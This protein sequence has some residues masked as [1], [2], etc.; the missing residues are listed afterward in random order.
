M[1]YIVNYIVGLITLFLFTILS[2]LGCNTLDIEKNT[3]WSNYNGDK[4]SSH[5]S[6]LA[7]IDTNNVQKLKIAWVFKSNDADTAGGSVIETNPVIIDGVLYGVSPK[8]KLFALN[9]STGENLWTFDPFKLSN[10][11]TQEGRSFNI[12]RGIAYWSDKDS[13]RIFYSVGS[14]L[15]AVDS[16][17]G[18]IVST[19][20]DHGIVDLHAGLDKS[21][22][23]KYISATSP[24]VIYKDLL[25]IGSAVNE[26]E[27]AASGHIRA[28]NIHSGNLEWVFHTIPQPGEF[29]Y[30]TWEDKE[31]WK[32]TGGAN[33]WT[34]MTLDEKR[35]I[36]Y[37]PTGSAT[38]DQYGGFRKGQNLFANCLLAL[39]AATGKHIWHYQTVH[40]DVWDMDANVPP[41]L[42]TIKRGGKEIDAV[43]QMTKPGFVF[44]FNRE[45]GEPIFPIDEVPADTNTTLIGE[46]L[47]PTQPIPRL[48]KPIGRSI[49]KVDDI[50][51][52]ISDSSREKVIEKLSLL[53]NA[54]ESAFGNR[55][56]PPSEKGNLV[57]P[58]FGGGPEWGGGAYDPETN[59]LFVNCNQIPC[60]Y[61]VVQNDGNSKV[62]R[63]RTV[64]QHGRQVY[65]NYCMACH[66]QNKEGGEGPSLIGI[67]HKYTIDQALSIINEGRGRMPSY[68]QMDK[69]EKNTL[70][71]FLFD[72]KEKGMVPYVSTSKDVIPSDF[73]SPTI[74][75]KRT[76]YPRIKS[77][78]G[79][80]AIMP[81][82]GTLSAINLNTGEIEWVETLGEYPALKEKGLAPTGTA[83]YGGPIVTAGGLIF[84]AATED[85]KIRAF[86][87]FTG[88][89][90][91]EAD[92]PAT[93]YAT[94][95]TYMV[96]GK[97]YLVI[98]CGGGMLAGSMF[99]LG[100][101]DSY[102]AFALP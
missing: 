98:A 54:N 63:K 44:V 21:D 64:F 47:W 24:G 14:N 23:G 53:V 66:G 90:L 25:I 11:R 61:S 87:K 51:P 65:M 78:E 31:A 29:G 50:D 19:F 16:K 38:P 7:Q 69:D 48:P 101:G 42:V 60:E 68:R 81:P 89:L 91:W 32:Y 58:G 83:N 79:Y 15:I 37:I 102:V 33:C 26:T 9:A 13:S 62:S 82:W 45:N 43:V 100:S 17:K 49:F 36:V 85:K 27:D 34:G 94:P 86:N 99:N 10:R 75:Y 2:F 22:Q 80:P 70:L 55:F 39:D 18:E 41:N 95:A 72:L 56:I 97:Q 76:G 5:Y 57:Y 20:G 73:I 84:I 28:F 8:L 92:L 67:N 59:L 1:K 4:L 6:S 96:N 88:K 46:K 12:C 35:G 74:P 71:T 93:G 30:D 40:H 77:L 52:D 3:D